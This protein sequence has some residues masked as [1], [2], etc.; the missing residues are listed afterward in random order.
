MA[1]S[2]P[3]HPACALDRGQR[4]PGRSPCPQPPRRRRRRGGPRPPHPGRQPLAGRLRLLQLPR[5]GPRPRG[6][7]GH[8]RLPGALGH[9]PELVAD[10]RQPCPVR[11]DRAAADRAARRRGHPAAADPDPHPR[12]GHPGPDRRRHHPAGRAGPQDHLRRLHGRPRQR[13]QRGPLPPQRPG[14]AGATAQGGPEVAP[15]DLH[16]RGQQ[17]DRQPAAAGRVRGPG[18]RAR[19]AAVPGRRPRLRRGRGA[20]PGRVVPLRA[21][22]QQRRAPPG[23]ELR[24]RGADGRLLQGVLLA[25]RLRRLLLR[26]QAGAQGDRPA[27]PVL[28]AVAD[29]LAGQRPGRPP[30]QRHPRRPAAGAD[31]RRRPAHPG[32]PG[33]DGRGHPQ[34]LGVPGRRG[35]ARRPRRPRPRRALPVRPRHVRHAGVLPGRAPRR[36]GLPPAGHRRQHRRR[37]GRAAGVLD[38][39][40][41][42]VPL[43]T[44]ASTPSRRPPDAAGRRGR[45]FGAICG[46]VCP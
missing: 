27:V 3:R 44:A 2:R 30:G 12:L 7:R 21:P 14:G 34:R 24:Q 17:H 29:R 35:A 10:A 9:P 16:G 6:D 5:P 15:P 19:R 31:P 22:R 13:R 4:R 18:A 38:L 1:G 32:P 43:R 25:A 11:A 41:D 23:G 33:R 40:A 8:P 45:G 46:S 28:R 42:T 26:P 36:G 37:G 39:L 20:H